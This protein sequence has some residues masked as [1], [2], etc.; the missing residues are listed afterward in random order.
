M[1]DS[2]NRCEG[3]GRFGIV[4]ESMAKKKK[5]TR[6]VADG[7][8]REK[9]P[10]AP[11]AALT[12]ATGGRRWGFRLLA[13]VL[14][15]V[16]LLALFEGVLWLADY[17]DPTRFFLRSRIN[18]RAVYIENQ[19]F[20]RRFFPPALVRHPQPCVL[21]SRKAPGTK[22]IFVIGESAA[23]GD[24][25][26]GFGLGRVM[27]VLLRERYPDTKFEVANVSITAINSHVLLP[28]ARDCAGRDGDAWV[29][30]MGNN[31][32]VGP[33]GAGTVFSPQTPPLA[34]IRL[35]VALKA[36]RIGQALAAVARRA[37]KST[38]TAWGGMEMF[39][40]QRV[41]HDDPKMARVYANFARNLRDMIELG[42]RSGAKVVVSTLAANLKDCAPFASLHRL[43]LAPA[44]LAAWERD[45]DQG[46]KYQETNNFQA[47]LESFARAARRD[48]DY[49]DLAY[50][51]G[52][53]R[54]AL[55]QAAAAKTS[56]ERALELDTLRFRPD[57]RINE[58]IRQAAGGREADG[59]FF[60]D[61]AAALARKAPG[62]LP[63]DESLY[64]HVHPTFEGNYW[65][66][67]ALAEQVAAALDLKKAAG[68]WLAWADCE[69]RLAL[70]GWDRFQGIETMVKR[71]QQPP[72]VNQSDWRER[73]QR[74]TEQWNRL[75]PLTKPNALRQATGGYRQELARWP[76][77]WY[78]HAD[79]ARLLQTLG[80][81]ASALEQWRET[82]RLVPHYAMASFSVGTLLDTQ[83]KS[84][85][86]QAYFQE[87]IRLRPE[88]PEA[89]NGLGLTLVGQGKQAE[90]IAC[91]RRA[92]ALNPEFAEGHVNLG[93]VYAGMGKI[94]EAVAEYDT[95]LKFK[96]NSPSAHINLGK[97]LA[98]Q[99]RVEEAAEHYRQSV[100]QMPEEPVGHYNL[101]NAYASLGR[102]A[103][104]A[105]Q[106]ALALQLKPDF[107][108]ARLNY[109]LELA[110][111]GK[112]SE[113]AAQ[114]QAAVKQDP[115]H[116]D[117]HFNLGVAYAGMQQWAEAIEQFQTV[118]KLDP[119]NAQARQSLEAAKA[120][121]KRGQ[122]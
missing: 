7:A 111:Q 105:A 68:E 23:M 45:F 46:V 35:N 96:S 98:R 49:A 89:L 69:R 3:R 94:A 118:L 72:F 39:L 86:A 5:L 51:M 32:V 77:D 74:W 66:G 100:E 50:R 120:I 30:Y 87:A 88:F 27:E 13:L 55:G 110:K 6:S 48:A 81:D 119:G 103:E 40:N 59:V 29:I 67:R 19:R 41:R 84:A 107:T 58:T 93:L 36:T 53:C 92:I 78:L 28:I 15:P 42:R 97:L 52:H 102:S 115:N 16:G 24:P 117:A 47:A 113:A 8:V 114:F 18:D 1:T 76:N 44:D 91:Y 63:G 104:A 54:L 108:E 12:P 109:G 2:G 106:Y 20:G 43:D 95:A 4:R 70:T 25:E 79:F 83:G 99:G 38:P 112:K 31:E 37:D 21:E 122:P 71:M 73:N 75:R 22:R 9:I 33:F 85:E 17:G 62:N 57:H 64:E 26:P 56:F 61:A 80:E 121:R 65:I 116:I 101:A 34:L 10:E 60:A 14:L 11:A 90:A 82:M